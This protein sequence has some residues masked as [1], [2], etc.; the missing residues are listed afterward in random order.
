MLDKQRNACQKTTH[1]VEVF[2]ANLL[3]A[4]CN[5]GRSY[6]TGN[7]V[8]IAHWFA[9]GDNVGYDALRFKGPHV[10]GTTKAHLHLIG[11]TDAS[12]FVHEPRQGK[13]NKQRLGKVSFG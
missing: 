4:A 5:F 11:D 3:K 12:S 7:W 1:R 10:A 6:D 9:D 13:A 8:A 2:R